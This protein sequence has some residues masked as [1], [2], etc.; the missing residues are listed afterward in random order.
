MTVQKTETPAYVTIDRAAQHFSV[1]TS[2]VRA[3]VRN[4]VI[5]K[6]TYIKLGTTYR[7]NLRDMTEA[8]LMHDARE[9]PNKKDER[10]QIKLYEESK[11]N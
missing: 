10:E 1:S 3:W 8:L 7:F 11:L 5:P 6:E 9:S 4:S 2:T